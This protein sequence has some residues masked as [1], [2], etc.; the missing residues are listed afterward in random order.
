MDEEIKEAIEEYQCSG[1]TSGSDTS[2]HTSAFGGVGCGRHSAGTIMHGVG[3]L[4]LG[5]PI[6]FNRLGVHERLQ[7]V[8]YKEYSDHSKSGY[9]MWNIPNWK[10]LNEDGHTIV[11]GLM[12]RRNEPFLHI[13]LEDC[14]DK[15]NCLEI[16][17]EDIEGMD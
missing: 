12:P 7:P 11:R 1:C 5:M 17:A 6:G 9:N 13:F 3:K 16:S 4:F 8:M 2:C 14:I 15:I 10:H